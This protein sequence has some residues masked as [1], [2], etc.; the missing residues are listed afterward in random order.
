MIITL[1][2]ALLGSCEVVNIYTEALEPEAFRTVPIDP[3]TGELIIVVAGFRLEV[4]PVRVVGLYNIV[5]PALCNAAGLRE[6]NVGDVERVFAFVG[7]GEVFCFDCGLM[8][9]L[10]RALP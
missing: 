1:L 6:G 2:R 7:D 8:D 10:G 5:V 3:D 9:T 4:I